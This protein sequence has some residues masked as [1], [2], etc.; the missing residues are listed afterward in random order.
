VFVKY[1]GEAEDGYDTVAWL[2]AQKHWCNGSVATTGPSYLCHVQTS[3]ALLRPPNLKCLFAN[4][5]GFFNSWTSGVRQGGAYEARQWVWGVKNAPRRDP[6]VKDAL[7]AVEKH[8]GAWMK[9]YPF[10]QGDSPLT[11]APE[12]EEF[13]FAQASHDRYSEFW[14]QVG[15]NTEEHLDR[16][17]D[18]P[19]LWLSGFYDI[20]ARSTCEFFRALSARK[21]GPHLL[22]MGPWQHV[23]PEGHVAGDVDFGVNALISGNLALTVPN[24]ARKSDRE[25][26]SDRNNTLVE[27]GSRPA[28]YLC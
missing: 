10:R 9:R 15:L 7:E 3:M 2:A 24:L 23:G 11:A 12:Y 27:P 20:Y 17:A 5:G 16:F 14:K 4:K 28:L 21:K 1:T 8:F 18:V 26:C 19:V 6:L 13:V 22:V 25:T